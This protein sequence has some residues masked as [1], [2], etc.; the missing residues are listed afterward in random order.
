MTPSRSRRVIGVFMA[1]AVSML[2]A[3]CGSSS[4][5][6]PSAAERPDEVLHGDRPP[7]YIFESL[8][9]LVATSEVIVVGTVKSASKGARVV[10]DDPLS[11]HRKVAV[12][13]EEQFY[14]PATESSIIVHQSG[15]HGD[16]SFEL[17]ELPWLYPGDRAVYFLVHSPKSPRDHYDTIA[18]PGRLVIK[19]N[20]TVSTKASDPIARELDGQSWSV[21]AQRIRDAVQTV[22]DRNI[23]P[24]PPGP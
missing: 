4:P 9:R 21:V 19:N 23:Q 8:P 12:H 16:S 15:Y 6:G 5:L 17:R 20:D 3:G 2:L 24:L 10:P 13:V 1:F 18:A 7:G 14:G 11:Y 22:Q